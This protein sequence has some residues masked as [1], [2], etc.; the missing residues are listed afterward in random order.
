M[1]FPL[2]RNSILKQFIFALIAVAIPSIKCY[3]DSSAHEVIVHVRQKVVFPFMG[4]GVQWDPYEYQPS[5]ADW[6]VIQERMQYCK[7]GYLRVMWNANSYCLGFRADG[8]PEYVWQK[9]YSVHR[10]ELDKLCGIL[11]FA[12]QQHI[13][14]ILGEWSPPVGLIKD[15]T[16][17]RWAKI[18]ADLLS[19]LR[20]ERGFT[21]IKFYNVINEP[22]GSW[23]G[24]KDYQTWESVVKTLYQEFVRR[25]LNKKVL[26]IGPDT[27]GNTQWLEPFT[28]LDRAANDLASQIGAW[29]L[30]WY[31]LDPEV[32]DDEIEA[33]LKLKK[34]MLGEHGRVVAS[35]PLFIGESGLLTGKMNGD[36]QPRVKTFGYGVM[37]ADYVAQVARA[38]WMGATAWDLDDAMHT[39]GAYQVPP[40]PL[41]LKVWGFWNSQGAAMGNPSDFDVRP[42]FYTWSL[43]SRLFP[44]GCSILRTTEPDIDRFRAVASMD[45]RNSSQIISVMLVNDS[46]LPQSVVLKVP[47][48][49]SRVNLKMYR[50]FREQHL[51][52]SQGFPIPYSTLNSTVLSKGVKID[53]PSRGVVFLTGTL[54]R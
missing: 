40:G 10:G 25:G 39:V 47:T 36:Q 37:M 34:K 44:R 4:L 1:E 21:C 54:A 48:L 5:S 28:W 24:N 14:V 19:Y 42:W 20:K 12:E 29:D 26:I 32:Y 13:N 8:S 23:S 41:T 2:Q 38:G 50:Y 18:T 3:S 46:N 22:N 30:H 15:E 43:M 31:A 45:R 27:T 11:S 52:N 9:G 33:L 17:P 51:H 7:P 49:T 16:D 35:K 6:K 53:L